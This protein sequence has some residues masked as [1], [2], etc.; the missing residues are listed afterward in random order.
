MTE[1]PS[2][3]LDSM[4]RP[5]GL[6]N[7]ENRVRG[8]LEEP[9]VMKMLISSGEELGDLVSIHRYLHALSAQGMAKVVQWLFKHH[10][11]RRAIQ[12]HELSQHRN[13]KQVKE[14]LRQITEWARMQLGGPPN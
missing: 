10:L 14:D 13:R 2:Q 12:R 6:L 1:L 4:G 11:V 3:I 7:L 5:V 9:R 8:W